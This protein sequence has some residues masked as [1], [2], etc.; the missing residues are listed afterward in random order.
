MPFMV[1][2]IQQKGAFMDIL[3]LAIIIVLI[4]GSWLFVKLVESV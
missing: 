2:F 3:Y 1:I 4:A